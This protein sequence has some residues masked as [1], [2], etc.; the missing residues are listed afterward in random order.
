MAQTLLITGGTGALGQSLLAALAATENIDRIYA[1]TRRSELASQFTKVRIVRGDVT[2]GNTLGLHPALASEI[3]YEVTAI[4]HGAANTRFSAP[5]GTARRV[6]CEG[7][8]HMLN[9]AAGCRRLERFGY[10]S[11]VYVAGKRRGRISESELNH[12][13]GFVNAYEQSKFEAEALLRLH[14]DRLPIGVFR[15]STILGEARTG[16]VTKI[17]AVHHALRFIYRGLAPMIPGTPESRV[18]LV[19]L[20]YAVSAVVE[21][22]WNCFQPG[23]T[24]HVCAGGDA[25]PLADFLDMTLAS[26]LRWRPAWRKR[27]IEKPA[28]VD[29]TTFRLFTR[30]VE[31]IGEPTLRRSVS[32]IKHFAPQLAYP[33]LFDD[34]VCARAL[35]G[36]LVVRPQLREF[37]PRVVKFLVE[38]RWGS[39]LPPIPERV[40]A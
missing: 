18:D 30:S 20:E 11:T 32:A 25:L 8:R 33:K 37:F 5:L 13:T 1:L 31:E 19:S 14:K 16:T 12:A 38:T 3:A 40:L 28:V 6:N 26:F 39:R 2:R 21:L 4:L 15:L 35:A 34:G 7:T 22:F 17:G 10:L 27:T 9:F 24:Y 36:S 23:V 29:L